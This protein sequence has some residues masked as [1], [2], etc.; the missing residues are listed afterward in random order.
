MLNSVHE[1]DSSHEEVLHLLFR[2]FSFNTVD[3]SIPVLRDEVRLPELLNLLWY[4]EINDFEIIL[5]VY[6]FD[7]PHEVRKGVFV[8][9]KLLPHLLSQL[10]SFF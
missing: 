10:L 8:L 3:E 9:P 2:V 1:V 4:L 6:Y 7:P 5:L